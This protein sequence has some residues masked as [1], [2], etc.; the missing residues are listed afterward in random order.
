MA[1]MTIQIPQFSCLTQLVIKLS[2]PS[3][4]QVLGQPTVTRPDKF[5][6]N[7]AQHHGFLPPCQLYFTSTHAAEKCISES[8]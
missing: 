8:L 1:K 3:T 6:I 5:A 7:P 2:A 4:M